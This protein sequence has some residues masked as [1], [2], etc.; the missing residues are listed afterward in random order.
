MKYEFTDAVWLLFIFLNCQIV[1][2]GPAKMKHPKLTDKHRTLDPDETMTARRQL[3]EYS[4]DRHPSSLIPLICGNDHS[5]RKCALI[6][7]ITISAGGA[8]SSRIICAEGQR[9]RTLQLDNVP[10][11]PFGSNYFVAR[12]WRN[13]FCRGCKTSKNDDWWEHWRLPSFIIINNYHFNTDRL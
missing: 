13:F 4:N 10:G 6:I 9:W 1:L 5:W 3:S 8:D 2:D 11:Y 7:V 12:F